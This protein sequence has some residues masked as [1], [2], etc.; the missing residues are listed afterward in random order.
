VPVKV[1]DHSLDGGR[2][3]IATTENIWRPML[4][5]DVALAA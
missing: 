4:R 1:N 3:A 5:W 2:Y